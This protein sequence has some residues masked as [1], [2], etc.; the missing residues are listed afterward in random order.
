MTITR[1]N[2]IRI[3][4]SFFC[5]ML[6]LIGGTTASSFIFVNNSTGPMANYTSIQQAIDNAD[7]EDIIML[8]PGTYH[9]NVDV[10]KQIS[11]RS[12]TGNKNDT[13]VKAESQKENV[14]YVN[15]NNVSIEGM[16]IEGAIN[17]TWENR[18]AG[19]FLDS[20]HNCTISNNRLTGNY[21][22]VILI[23][24]NNNNIETN[25]IFNNI[26]GNGI[27]L[28]NSDS[29]TLDSNIIN[30]NWWS[31]IYLDS[32][33]FNEIR[34]NQLESN[35][36]GI[37]LYK[38]KNNKL[39]NNIA[40]SNGLYGI[41]LDTDS[42]N[43][44]LKKNTANLNENSGIYLKHSSSNILADNVADSNYHQGILMKFS[45]GN[46][47]INNSVSNNMPGSSSDEESVS[48]YGM[49]LTNCDENE[50]IGNLLH[51]NKDAGIS[52]QE[53][54][55][56]HITG[57]ILLSTSTGLLIS[58]SNGNLIYDNYFHNPVNVDFTGLNFGNQWNTSLKEETNIL[59]GDLKGGN[60]WSDPYYT[61]HSQI[62]ED[63]DLDGICD[64]PYQING[65]NEDLLPLYDPTT[66]WKGDYDHDGDVD[67][68][69]F[70][71][72]AACYNSM[73][74]ENNYQRIFDFEGDYDVDFNDFVEFA[75][76]YQ[77]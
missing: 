54:S 35:L 7:N 4:V 70:V 62:C 13:F 73:I 39:S 64:L 58:Y 2:M 29:N 23:E 16:T 25:D 44:E 27:F 18:I 46:E 57:N 42:N 49:Y 51:L 19:I 77:K 1:V 41:A 34:Y 53:S 12:L 68:D 31:G 67:F 65:E 24:S 3:S 37:N 56:N 66:S 32:S 9:E 30:S 36:E 52:I 22:G 14:F 20:A 21:E 6:L 43:N 76:D 60:F 50:I 40:N 10:D 71:E 15:A 69:D 17:C 11:I 38:S 48:T 55:Q 33:D 26:N 47:I 74:G 5:A 63:L 61:G 28:H 8:H 59:N 45:S 75:G 72:F